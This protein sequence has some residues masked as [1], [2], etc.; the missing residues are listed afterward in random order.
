M[1]KKQRNF[2]NSSVDFAAVTAHVHSLGRFP[3][4]MPA[5]GVRAPQLAQVGRH[6]RIL[7]FGQLS[8]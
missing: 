5:V 2:L 6:G 3:E 7:L 1:L 8:Q 4:K